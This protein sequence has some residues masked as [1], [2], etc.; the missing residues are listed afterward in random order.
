M[1]PVNPFVTI[2]SLA[3]LLALPAI[4]SAQETAKKLHDSK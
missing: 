1:K 3:L 2:S 4:T